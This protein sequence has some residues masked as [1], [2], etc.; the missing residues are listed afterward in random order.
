[1]TAGRTEAGCWK[2]VAMNFEI[3]EYGSNTGLYAD[4]ARGILQGVYG[5][6]GTVI[7]FSTIRHRGCTKQVFSV[8]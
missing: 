6:A 1:M 8:F 4:M 5:E 2:P 3:R 7:G